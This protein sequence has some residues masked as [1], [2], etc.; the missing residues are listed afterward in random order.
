MRA[1]RLPTALRDDVVSCHLPDGGDQE[2]GYAVSAEVH[3]QRASIA[4]LVV[5]D[6]RITCLT[7]ERIDEIQPTEMSN[8]G[9]VDFVEPGLEI[10]EGIGRLGVESDTSR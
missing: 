7:G 1:A 5:A 8:P 9:E 6:D 4:G 2:I 10:H 3:L